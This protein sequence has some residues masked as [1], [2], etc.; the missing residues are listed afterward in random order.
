MN[1]RANYYYRDQ[2]KNKLLE[3]SEQSD[4]DGETIVVGDRA[5]SKSGEV[6]SNT[7]ER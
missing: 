2:R 4:E 7:V 1:I 6:G 3:S 5:D